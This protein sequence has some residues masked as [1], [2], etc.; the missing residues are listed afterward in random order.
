MPGAWSHRMIDL[1]LLMHARPAPRGAWC[2]ITPVPD[3]SLRRAWCPSRPAIW[4]GLGVA[5]RYPRPRPVTYPLPRPRGEPASFP[6]FFFFQAED[7]I[8]DLTV[9]G[10]QTCALP[11]LVG[12][13]GF[14]RFGGEDVH[15]PLRVVRAETLHDLLD[16]AFLV[17]LHRG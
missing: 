16:A 9:T 11:I 5:D 17:A 6:M 8:R 10:V 3:V 15:L 4:R 13:D 1:A 7:G 14:A 2:H 12:Q